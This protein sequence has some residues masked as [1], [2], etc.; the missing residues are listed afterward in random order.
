MTVWV[1]SEHSNYCAEWTDFSIKQL[2]RAWYTKEQANQTNLLMFTNGD[3][4]PVWDVIEIIDWKRRK[5][6]EP[7][8]MLGYSDLLRWSRVDILGEQ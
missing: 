6:K 4:R 1:I 2:N 7:V 3:Q 8:H 5:T